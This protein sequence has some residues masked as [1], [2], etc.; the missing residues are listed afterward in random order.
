ME[1]NDDGCVV[2][3][4]CILRRRFLHVHVPGAWREVVG[5]GGGEGG[6]GDEVDGEVP[7]IEGIGV[8]AAEVVKGE[9]VDAG[10][11]CAEDGLEVPIEEVGGGGVGWD[12]GSGEG[13]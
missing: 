10:G 7:A 13:G 9:R 11:Y 8:V 5:V 4:R 3:C 2:L 12:K 1:R 6:G